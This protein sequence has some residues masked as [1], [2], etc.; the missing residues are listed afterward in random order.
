MLLHAAL[1]LLCWISTSNT[2][3]LVTEGFDIRCTVNGTC[4]NYISI[5]VNF[6]SNTAESF[7]F[8]YNNGTNINVTITK[9]IQDA[10]ALLTVSCV[11][12]AYSRQS[13]V[14]VLKEYGIIYNKFEAFDANEYCDLPSSVFSGGLCTRLHARVCCSNTDFAPPDS[15]ARQPGVYCLVSGT[16]YWFVPFSLHRLA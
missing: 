15:G 7:N 12:V 2:A 6:T 13:L 11:I 14:L 4:S 8:I 10:G 9:P 16:K 3:E 1:I 5:T